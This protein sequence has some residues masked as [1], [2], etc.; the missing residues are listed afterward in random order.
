[1][2]LNPIPN[3]NKGSVQAFCHS[4]AP[5]QKPIYVLHSPIPGAPLKACF[6]IVQQQVLTHGGRQ[7]TGWKMVE[8]TNVRLE[9]EFHVVWESPDGDLIDIT[10]Q[11]H[12]FS[13]TL[14][15]PDP[16]RNNGGTWVTPI[17]KA[18]THR[19]GTQR[20]I[21]TLEEEIQNL[22]QLEVP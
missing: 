5:G 8:F 1:M 7:I 13:R 20:L 16:S 15:L 19:T 22:Q 11:E 9:A 21:D 12:N 18:V 4:I 2:T 17:L 10:P 3:K 14:F 6:T